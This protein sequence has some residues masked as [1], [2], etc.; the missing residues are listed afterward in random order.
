[1]ADKPKHK[2]DPGQSQ[3]FINKA[4]ELGCDDSE[5]AFDE[6][7]RKVARHTP[8]DDKGKSPKDRKGEKKA[9]S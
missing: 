7:L 3:R 6:A 2:D 9:G 8:K 1:M 4:R 5:E